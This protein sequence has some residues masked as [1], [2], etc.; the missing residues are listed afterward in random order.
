MSNLVADLTA[1]KVMGAG[2]G[3]RRYTET[4]LFPQFCCKHKMTLKNKI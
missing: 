1:G 4:V 3:T 2:E